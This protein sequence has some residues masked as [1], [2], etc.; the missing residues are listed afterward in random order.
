M[1]NTM[2]T[3]TILTCAVTGNLTTRENHPGLPVTPEEI[4]KYK[5]DEATLAKI[6][7]GLPGMFAL[8]GEM[9]LI[10]TEE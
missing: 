6:G 10:R 4:A 5:L 7:S 8:I 1:T 2:N 9:I 3:P